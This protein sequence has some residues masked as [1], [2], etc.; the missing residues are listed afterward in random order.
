VDHFE[1]RQQEDPAPVD[2]HVEGGETVIFYL[3]DL[4]GASLEDCTHSEGAIAI[5][6]LSF[7]PFTG[8]WEGNDMEITVEVIPL[9]DGRRAWV[10]GGTRS[11]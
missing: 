8:R 9:S 1:L 6:M 10:R 3:R 2:F 5:E 4:L 7:N 11:R